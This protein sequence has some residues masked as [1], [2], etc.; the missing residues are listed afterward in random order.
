MH[1]LSS[2]TIN[3]PSILPILW[4][5]N[6]DTATKGRAYTSP[7]LNCGA[8]N[9]DCRWNPAG[10]PQTPF[11]PVSG[12]FGSLNFGSWDGN[13]AWVYSRTS[14]IVRSDTSAK[15]THVARTITPAQTQDVHLDPF[16]SSSATGVGLSLWLCG[17]NASSAYWC[18]FRP[19]R[20][21]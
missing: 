18:Y 19:D 20:E 6:G 12:T 2:S 9:S 11:T 21:Q 14:P 4:T 15:A 7:A 1:G 17:P 13:T 10:P 3:S 5:G 16:N 8:A